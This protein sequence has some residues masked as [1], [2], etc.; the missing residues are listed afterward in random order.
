MLQSRSIAAI[1][2]AGEVKRYHT[3]RTIGVQSVGEHS[4][5]VALLVFALVKTPSLDLIKAALLHDVAEVSVGDIPAPV[6]RS[7]PEMK[8]QVN[9]LEDDF[10]RRIGI[11]YPELSIGEENIL[12]VADTLELV[13]YCQEQMHMGNAALNPVYQTGLTYL[14][15]YLDKSPQVVSQKVQEI[16]S[17][18]TLNINMIEQGEVIN[19]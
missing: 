7:S 3:K 12:K 5:N 17:D 4:W 9:K 15:G 19:E 14:Y 13:L 16:L 11:D 8:E 10:L 6:K 2:I 18:V 1:R